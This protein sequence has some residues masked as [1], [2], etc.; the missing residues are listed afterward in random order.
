MS[1]D[2]NMLRLYEDALSQ[3]NYKYE[4]IDPFKFMDGDI[5]S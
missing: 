3:L 5:T 1:I 4:L 2:E